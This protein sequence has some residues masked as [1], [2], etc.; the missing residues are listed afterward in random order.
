M[1]CRG[2]A[3]LRDAVVSGADDVR[4]GVEVCGGVVDLYVVLGVVGSPAVVRD[5]VVDLGV[6]ASTGGKHMQ[7]T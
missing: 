2:G 3:D 6:V 4:S 5:R 1:F 7:F